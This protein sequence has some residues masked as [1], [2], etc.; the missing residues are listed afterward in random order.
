MSTSTSDY[1]HLPIDQME[2]IWSG[3]FKRARAALGLSSFGL[4]VSDLPPNFDQ[5][6]AHVHT[7]DQQEEVYIPL[8]GGGWMEVEGRRV[9][10]DTGTAV[11]VG[12]AARR[13]P[14]AGP[15]GL[16][17]LAVGCAPDR[18][19]EPFPP[20]EA[21]APEPQIGDLPGVRAAA[22][23]EDGDARQDGARGDGDADFTVKRFDEMETLGGYFKGVSMTPLRRE[24]GVRAFGIGLID[25]EG[26]PDAEYPHHDH[27]DDGQEEVYIPVAGEGEIEIEGIG[28]VPLAV[29]EMVRVG[30]HTK[31]RIHPGP[32]GIRVIAIGGTPGKA[33]EPPARAAA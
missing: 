18:P 14:I 16:R 5:V 20:S 6:P 10:I 8:A 2:A 32:S 4:S 17:L 12:P 33:Y 21:G 26:I 9:P 13:R 30:P 15:D 19:Y 23:R 22:A 27:G 1:K 3:G 31:R 29:G 25:I 24:L 7:F 11:R 28:R